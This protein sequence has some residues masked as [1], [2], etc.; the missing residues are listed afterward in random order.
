VV[1]KDAGD[2][3]RTFNYEIY[4]I[5]AAGGEPR[6]ISNF[7]GADNDP[8]WES[9]PA[10]SPDSSKL[11]WLE[12]GDDKWIYYSSYQLAWADIATGTIVRPARID[13]PFTHPHWSADGRSIFALIEGSRDTLLAKIDATS[14]AIDYLTKG[15]RFALDFAVAHDDR[16]LIGDGDVNTPLALRTVEAAPRVLSAQ[17][18]WIKDRTLAETR[19]I[20]FDS[21]GTRIDAQLV[22][23]IGYQPGKRYPLIVRLHGGPVYQFS[24]EFMTDWQIYAA[25]GYAVLGI[26][27]RGSSGRG[28]AFASAIYADW[29]GPDVADIKAGIDHVIA[30]G[31]ADP[32]RIGTGGWSYGGILTD[33]MIASEPRLKA[34]ISGAGLGNAFG[35]FGA[36]MYAREYLYELGTPWGNF[37]AY[38][39]VSFPFFSA[40]KIRVPTLFQ[41]AGKDFNVPCIGAEQMYLAL[42]TNNVPTRLVVYPGE[43]H[44]LSVP[45]YLKDRMERDVAWYD[46]WLKK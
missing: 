21:G 31:I 9:R 17:Y 11:V 29:G 10:W 34:A 12:G 36:D 23:P 1:G 46:Q 16:I 41:C 43:N 38:K 5:P 7:A 20:S 39:K 15:S 35:S 22:L 44:G 3:D 4:L 13:R 19:D 24:H 40:A 45:R 30:L 25:N 27:P 37:D 42:K 26:N 28:F 2:A 14:G 8:G 33:A 32:D 18:G 6:K